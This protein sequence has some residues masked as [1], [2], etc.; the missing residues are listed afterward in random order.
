MQPCHR[1]AGPD[2]EKSSVESAFDEIDQLTDCV[3]LFFH[4]QIDAQLRFQ[5]HY[6]LDGVERINA[7]R[8]KGRLAGDLIRRMSSCAAR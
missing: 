2:K 1:P 7:Q 8:F 3:E 6:H 4:L 5:I